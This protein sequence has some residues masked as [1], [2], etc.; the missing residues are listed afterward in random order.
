MIFRA[1]VCHGSLGST[2]SLQRTYPAPEFTDT[3][4]FATRKNG[5]DRIY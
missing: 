5:T 4:E 3:E 2:V 1:S